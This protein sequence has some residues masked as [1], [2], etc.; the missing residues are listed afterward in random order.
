M[1]TFSAA[2]RL[3]N[4]IAHKAPLALGACIMQADR[5]EID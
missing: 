3:G 4:G 5:L 2:D 1:D